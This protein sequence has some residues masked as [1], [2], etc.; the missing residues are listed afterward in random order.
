[1]AVTEYR[2][3][4]VIRIC[5]EAAMKEEEQ[6]IYLIIQLFSIAL[7]QKEVQ[8]NKVLSKMGIML[9]GK[10][11]ILLYLELMQMAKGWED[12]TSLTKLRPF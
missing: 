9:M 2:E 8:S 7:K 12:K 5:G 10:I 3:G 6:N 11:L 4:L 1:M